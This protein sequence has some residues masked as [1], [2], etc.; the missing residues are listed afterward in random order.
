MGIEDAVDAPVE[1]TA[2]TQL[3]YVV[4]EPIEYVVEAAVRDSEY[5]PL[6]AAVENSQ[7]DYDTQE[8]ASHQYAAPQIIF[9]APVTYTAPAISY[10]APAPA[11]TYCAP[12]PVATYF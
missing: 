3:D 2:L 9:G 10:T 4:E 1:F 11:V 12:A 5:P 8:N 6:E 7:V